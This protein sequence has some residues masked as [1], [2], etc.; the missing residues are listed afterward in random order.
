MKFTVLTADTQKVIQ[1]STVCSALDPKERNLRINDIFDGEK[2]QEYNKS[3]RKSIFDG[4]MQVQEYITSLRKSLKD[5]SK[6]DTFA[7]T[8]DVLLDLEPTSTIDGETSTGVKDGG[9]PHFEP[10]DLVGRTFLIEPNEEGERQRARIV[11]GIVDQE[12]KTNP[13]K[14][15]IK[16]KI[17]EGEEQYDK[18]MDIKF[19][20]QVGE[21]QYDEA[22]GVAEI[23]DYD[24]LELD[25][26]KHFKGITE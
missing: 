15:H 17:Q 26:W 8:L 14:D 1:L 25:S 13:D 3:L 9:M 12:Q 22:I 4:G 20:I 7:Q 23:N 24:L 16:I 5:N 11:E 6:D 2:V 18:V 21:E 19:K 10:N